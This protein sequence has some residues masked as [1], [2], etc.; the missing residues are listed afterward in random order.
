M[1][2]NGLKIRTFGE[3][4]TD[5]V[6]WI[7]A[8]TSRL[9]DFN[10]GSALRTLTEAISIQFEEF[11][12]AVKQNVLYAI[13][14]AIYEAF[15]VKA[16]GEQPASGYVTVVFEEPLSFEMHFPKGTTFSTSDVYGYIYFASTQDIYAEP[17]DAGIRIPVVCKTTGEAGNVPAGAVNKIATS[18][19]II[20][21]V[22]NE[23]A[24][25]YGS[26]AETAT[27]RKRRF[28]HYIRTLSKGTRDAIIY[29]T[30]EVEG[31]AGACCDD[32]YIGF[33]KLYAHDANGDLPE[34]LKRR[35]VDNLQNYRSAGIEV[36][37]LPIVKHPVDV[38]VMIM[39]DNAYDPAI[40][41]GVLKDLIDRMLNEHTVAEPFYTA[42]MIHAIKDAYEDIV[43][44]IL[45]QKGADVE[46][47]DNELIRAGNVT[48]RCVTV[49]DWRTY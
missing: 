9:T 8:R 25:S 31:V 29:G 27:E 2:R 34:D 22:Y 15:G 45:I 1:S 16:R 46:V 7:T 44:N 39:I 4:F 38:D 35:I 47:A 14:T 11:Y 30:L 42:N 13:D 36:Q 48:V 26:N 24:F 23:N 49:H 6:E 18:N 43:V 40:Y 5:L 37:V 3:V 20:R 17:G 33:V 10:V 41:N 32:R 21:R 12:F 28:Q 19:R